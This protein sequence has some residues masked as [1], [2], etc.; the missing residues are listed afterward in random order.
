MTTQNLKKAAESPFKAAHERSDK[1]GFTLLNSQTGNVIA[2]VLRGKPGVKITVFPAMTRVD[3]DRRLEVVY[4]EIAE[5]LGEEDFGTEDFEEVVSTHYGRMVREDDRTIFFA[6]PEDA[7]E[8]LGL[9]DLL[10]R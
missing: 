6:N 10:V 2:E 5:A 4:A 8:Y 1:C 7:A 9:A 3:A